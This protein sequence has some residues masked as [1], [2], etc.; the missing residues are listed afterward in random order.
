MA[1]WLPCQADG[2]KGRNL[3][4]ISQTAL[5]AAGLAASVRNSRLCR[6]CQRPRDLEIL[7][8]NDARSP[9]VAA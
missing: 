8:V 5:T 4:R 7:I 2:G 9:Q 1:G 3:T 6:P